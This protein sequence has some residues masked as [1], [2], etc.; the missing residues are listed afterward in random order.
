M[1][2]ESLA[3]TQAHCNHCGGSRW[4]EVLYAHKEHSGSVEPALVSYEFLRCC[5]CKTVK[6]RRTDIDSANAE[7]GKK[8][9]PTITYY[10]PARVRPEPPWFTDLF[11]S[12]IFEDSYA[13]YRLLHEVYVALQNGAHSLAVMGIR[14]VVETVMIQSIGDSGSFK[15]N[16]RKLKA[17]GLISEL[18]DQHL[19]EVLEVGH[20]AIHR[21]H[22]PSVASVVGALDIAETLVKRLYLDPTTIRGLQQSTP[23]RK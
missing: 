6:L 5:G 7:A 20:A 9:A 13:V 18:D 10:P 1:P 22:E 8:V 16:L 11:E 21:A 14:A 4:H 15:E 3:Q 12:T 2:S 23:R 19:G 17:K